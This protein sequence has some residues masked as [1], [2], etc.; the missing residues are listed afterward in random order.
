MRRVPFVALIAAVLPLV[1]APAATAQDQL[2]LNGPCTVQSA[3]TQYPLG[4]NHD[5]LDIASHRASCRM[6]QEAFLPLNE[7][8]DDEV[9]GEMD[10]KAGIAAV[11]VSY[12]QAGVLF[13]DVT[14]PAN[15]RF[16]SRYQ[17]SE[18]EGAAADIDCGAFIDLSADGRLAF[19]SLQ[20]LTI[21]PGRMPPNPGALDPAFPGVEVIDISNPESPTLASPYPVPGDAGG[22]HT[23]RSHIVP[24]G[25]SSDDAP[26]EPGEYLF[27]TVNGFGVEVTRVV[28][29]PRPHLE[30]VNRIA[31]DEVHDMY[32][33]D[34]PTTGRTYMY[35]AAGF[36]SG[37]YVYDV[38]D[39]AQEV[40]LGEWD[41]TPHC[42]EDW[43]SHTIDVA[44]HNGRRY[45]TLPSE[46]FDF[47]EQ[48]NE[49]QGEGCGQIVGNADKPGPLWIVDATDFS[50]LGQEGDD[51]V[52]LRRKSEAALQATWTNAA[53]A[54]GGNLYHSPHNQQIV[55][56]KIYLSHYHAGVTVLDASGAFAGRRERPKEL[57]FYVPTGE[58]TRPIYEADAG[59]FVIPFISEFIQYRPLIWD[60]YY[61]RGYVL[62]ADE[63]GGFYSLRYEEDEPLPPLP[64]L[65]ETRPGVTTTGSG[66]SCRVRSGFRSVSARPRGSGLRFSFRRALP[67]KVRVDVFRESYG[68]RIVTRRVALF[69]ERTRAFTW[70]P[71]GRRFG[72]GAYFVR[73]VMPLPNGRLDMRRVALVRRNGRFRVRPPFY[74]RQGCG[75]IAAFKLSKSVF[76]GARNTPLGVSFVLNRRSQVFVQVLRG[77][78]VVRRYGP[79]EGIADLRTTRIRVPAAGLP[80]GDY[81]I[82]LQAVRPGQTVTEVLTARRL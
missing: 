20:Q 16:L 49:D 76:G 40:L 42:A 58:P 24:Q 78:R 3:R 21:V 50:R 56:E 70:R 37:F 82:R 69:R 32:I 75:M 14:D 5:H 39:P 26:R 25:P 9:L 53:A 80:R 64:P 72:D 10:V 7:D 6:V 11:A 63:T 34:D 60:M 67:R 28:R 48:S 45:V 19:L 17:S 38:T 4:D 41:L 59:P 33:Q 62:A 47:G 68:R 51:E 81:R 22:I 65:P 61:Y 8:L 31:V 43:Y 55:N 30:Q 12:P 36:A 54:P 44:T 23:A 1:A 52:T 27:L 2:E 74:R 35:I 57:G 15:P 77:R 71:R 73:F 29:T 79:I 13:F 18:C 66:S 46:L